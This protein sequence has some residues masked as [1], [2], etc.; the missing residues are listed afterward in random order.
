MIGHCIDDHLLLHY[1]QLLDAED[2]AFSEME[3]DF[4]EGDRARFDRDREAWMRAVAERL[5][6]LDRCGFVPED[7]LVHQGGDHSR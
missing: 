6:Y 1:R 3:H 5:A 4:E 2:L 7:L